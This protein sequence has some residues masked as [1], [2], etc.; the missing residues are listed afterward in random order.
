MRY[1]LVLFFIP[2]LCSSQADKREINKL[3]KELNTKLVSENATSTEKFD[4]NVNDVGYL[5]IERTLN[6]SK[7]ATRKF[8]YSMYLKDTDYVLDSQSHDGTT[9]YAFVFKDKRLNKSI[10]QVLK[11]KE[12]KS[13]N[14]EKT[15]TDNFVRLI[16]PVTL[17]IN[18]EDIKFC[19]EIFS[20]IF[21][22]AKNEDDYFSAYER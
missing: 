4:L 20:H 21:E 16:I 13:S 9:L 12:Y 14:P 3:I 18:E 17:T 1:L 5:Q 2:I 7:V 10:K 19:S 8:T 6:T 15:K 22:L 11:V